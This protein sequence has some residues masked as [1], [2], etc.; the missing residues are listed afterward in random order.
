MEFDEFKKIVT[1]YG[2]EH[3]IKLYER[4]DDKKRRDLLDQVSKIN[5]DEM[6]NLYEL[7]KVKKDFKEFKI[8]P[9]KACD[10][11]KL[12]D[13]EKEEYIK[14]GE[15]AIKNGKLAVVMLAGG[16]GTRLGHSGPKGTFDFGLDS[17][18]SIFETFIKQFK[19][20]EAK[21]KVAVPWYIMT[22]RDNVKDTIEFFYKNNYFD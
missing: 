5:F 11:S 19:E 17:H 3:L 21:Y 14:L 13:A 12:T 8:E 9:I 6:K 22:S 16:Q 15:E 2:Q 18:I 7:T 20:A 4:L 10:A 1:S